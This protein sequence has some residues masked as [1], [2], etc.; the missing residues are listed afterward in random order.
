MKILIY[1]I[2]I[3]LS[4]TNF[5]NADVENILKEIKKNKDLVMG[6]KNVKFLDGSSKNNWEI[7]NN[8]ILKSEKKTRKHV[9]KIVNK[10]DDYPV[11]LGEQSL[12][13]EVRH[14]NG[15]GWDKR[16]DRERVELKI[17]CVNKKITWTAWSIYLPKDY[18]VVFPIR[19][20]LGQ[21]HNDGDNPPAFTFENQ[22]VLI[23]GGY[24]L[25]VD[26]YIGGNNNNPKLLIDQSDM[27]GKWTDVLV[28]AK[29]TNEEDGFFKVW[30]NGKLK[31]QHTGMTQEKIDDMNFHIGV[32]RSF[33]SKTPGPDPTQV[34]YYDEVRHGNKCKKLKLKELGYSCKDIESQTFK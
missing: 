26:S 23:P 5:S 34:A 4:F 18:N 9:L 27:L 21:F 13:F 7:N 29:W 12:R 19:T 3:L 32:Y 17:C 8:D 30:V 14:G 16:N 24:W 31:A 1:V 33:L 15:W 22:G 28:N 20:M 11:R 6:F 10:A 25:E 2:S